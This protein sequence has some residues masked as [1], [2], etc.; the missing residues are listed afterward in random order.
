MDK[1]IFAKVLIRALSIYTFISALE[2][3]QYLGMMVA[4]L[5]QPSPAFI[6]YSIAGVMPFIFLLILGFFLWNR[7][8]YLAE[9]M[10]PVEESVSGG[11]VATGG[12]IEAIAFS[13]V[14]IY[15]LSNALPRLVEVV[16]GI[17]VFY[18]GQ[19]PPSY[20]Y[21][22]YS[23]ISSLAGLT[24]KMT[25]GFWLILGSRGI[26]RLVGKLREA[27]LKKPNPEPPS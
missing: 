19:Y 11:S 13:A 20:E 26:V 27:G 2:A 7:A 23:S 24:V 22:N 17:I 16:S 6:I 14:G 5:S 9:R 12:E 25:M 1:K 4:V 21:F 3:L 8:G 10:L 18:S 15:L